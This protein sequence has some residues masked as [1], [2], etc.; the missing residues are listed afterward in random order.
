[1]KFPLIIELRDKPVATKS[2]R[3]F[4]TRRPVTERLY[5]I[6]EH[7]RFYGYRTR[8]VDG[9]A[10]E[11]LEQAVVER[12][13]KGTERYNEIRAWMEATKPEKEIPDDAD[14]IFLCGLIENPEGKILLFT[15]DR[16]DNYKASLKQQFQATRE[17]F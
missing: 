13:R 15:Q 16:F 2:Y 11:Y 9:R 17:E 3:T 12:L 8:R 5:V 4:F 7:D 10:E 1:M 14:F 6:D